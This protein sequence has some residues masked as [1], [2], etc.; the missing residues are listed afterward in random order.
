M[1]NFLIAKSHACICVDITTGGLTPE[2]EFFWINYYPND[3]H[4]AIGKLLLSKLGPLK[5]VIVCPGKILCIGEKSKQPGVIFS[6]IPSDA[7]NCNLHKRAML[8]NDQAHRQPPT[9]TVERK[10]DSR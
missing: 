9:A 7:C 5:P 2:S 3:P 6:P 1:S 10:G 4:P 8:P